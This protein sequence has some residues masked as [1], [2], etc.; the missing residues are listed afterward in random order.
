[1]II[2]FTPY[3]IIITMIVLLVCSLRIYWRRY[4]HLYRPDIPLSVNIPVHRYT[5]LSDKIL[6][7]HATRHKVY[8]VFTRPQKLLISVI[9]LSMDVVVLDDFFWMTR[10]TRLSVC[11]AL[12]A[13]FHY[14]V[15]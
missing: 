7:R 10:V 8:D 12:V 14:M 4:L 1:M 9:R 15:V 11:T 3:L 2:L 5:P 6:I 13:R